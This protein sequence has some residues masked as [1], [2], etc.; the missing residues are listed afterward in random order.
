MSDEP[1]NLILRLLRDMR[2]E[3]GDMRSEMGDMRAVMATKQDLAELGADLRSEMHSLRADVASDIATLQAE[4]KKTRKELGDQIVGL[5]RAVME[6][7]S[8]VIG[9][10]VLISELEARMRRVEQ[11]LDLPAIDAH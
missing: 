5:R 11:H 10:G 8:S 2:A 1:D 7:H 3:I 6:Y 9:H 4:D